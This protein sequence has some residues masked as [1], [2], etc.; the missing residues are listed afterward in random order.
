[1]G[2]FAATATQSEQVGRFI[3]GHRTGREPAFTVALPAE[4][5]SRSRSVPSWN[6]AT[7]HYTSGSRPF[8]CSSIRK[9]PSASGISSEHSTSVTRV[10]GAWCSG[11]ATQTGAVALSRNETE[12]THRRPHAPARALQAGRS[13][14]QLH[15]F[16][17]RLRRK[18]AP[19]AGGPAGQRAPSAPF[20]GLV[21]PPVQFAEEKAAPRADQAR[22]GDP[23][24]EFGPPGTLIELQMF[25]RILAALRPAGVIRAPDKSARPRQFL[26]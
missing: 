6:R 8:T 16:A 15:F 11:Y 26:P 21:E 14:V 2:R 25:Q 18:T 24:R 7:S 22:S 5:S 4:G 9:S 23:G 13:G 1:M 17:K 20:E 3:A 12:E 19:D 10:H